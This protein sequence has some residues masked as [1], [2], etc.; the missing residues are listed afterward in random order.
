LKSLPESRTAKTTEK[1]NPQR[2]E[3]LAGVGVADLDQSIRRELNIPANIQGAVVTEVNPNSASYE[4]GLR[5]GD[6]ITEINRQPIRNA[7]DAI[8]NT[9]KANADQTLVKVWSKGGSHYLTVDES[10]ES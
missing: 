10:N 6:V 9:N 5:N 2:Q 8:D 4:A 7:Q 1:N 3:A